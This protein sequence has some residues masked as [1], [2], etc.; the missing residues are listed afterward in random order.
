MRDPFK[1]VA[2]ESPGMVYGWKD[3]TFGRKTGAVR[4]VLRGRVR[5]RLR[6]AD[7]S[8]NDWTWAETQSIARVTGRQE[9][10]DGR[11]LA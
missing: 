3:D 10:T 2:N 8:S 7:R 9:E 5:R 1:I 11:H 6:A 4:R